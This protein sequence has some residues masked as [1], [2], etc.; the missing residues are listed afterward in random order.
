MGTIT[1]HQ[2]SS[3]LR[4]GF[5][6][7]HTHTHTHTSPTTERFSRCKILYVHEIKLLWKNITNFCSINRQVF[8][9]KAKW[10]Q[11]SHA[12]GIQH[13]Y[14]VEHAGRYYF[15]QLTCKAVRHYFVIVSLTMIDYRNKRYQSKQNKH[16]SQ[17][18]NDN[19]NN[20][21]WPNYLFL[22]PIKKKMQD[23]VPNMSLVTPS[24]TVVHKWKS[25]HLR[26]RAAHTLYMQCNTPK[27]VETFRG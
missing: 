7:T 10:V 14:H 8:S 23:C 18:I 19:K 6:H 5:C 26:E 2:G 4:Y 17:P 9:V 13:H 20:N 21:E 16:N 11:I 15:I 25:F 27:A 12:H 24:W 22:N 1:I 3:R